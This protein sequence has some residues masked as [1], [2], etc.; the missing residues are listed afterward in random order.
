VVLSA[1]PLYWRGQPKLGEIVYKIVP[2]RD[3]LLAHVR[4]HKIAMWYQFGGAYLARIQAV[5]GYTVFEQPGY[6]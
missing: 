6:A 5:S 3:A 2:N 1:N 4:A